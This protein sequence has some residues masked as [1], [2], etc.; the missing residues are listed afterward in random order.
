MEEI[1]GENLL[2]CLD[3][4]A[5]HNE[6]AWSKRVWMPL[7]FFFGTGELPWIKELPSPPEMPANPLL[8]S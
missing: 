1:L 3:D 2:W 6:E 4:E 5:E 7:L 8:I